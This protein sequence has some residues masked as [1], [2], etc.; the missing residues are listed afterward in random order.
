MK[1]VKNKRES[2]R[3]S[4]LVPVE[5]KKGTSFAQ[6]QTVDISEGGIGLISK[7]AVALDEKIA[8]EI[9]TAPDA[10]PIL[11]LGKVVWIQ[12]LGREDRYRVGLKFQ[13]AFSSAA[14]QKLNRVITL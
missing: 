12:K 1:R 14:R 10:D 13:K 8:V 9:A 4:C 7:R 6:S 11:M 2:Q 5:G 3:K